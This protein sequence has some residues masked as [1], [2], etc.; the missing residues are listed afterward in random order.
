MTNTPALKSLKAV[1]LASAVSL[2]GACAHDATSDLAK[3]TLDAADSE[4]SV[5]DLGYAAA[6]RGDHSSAIQYFRSAHAQNIAYSSADGGALLGLGQSLLAIGQNSDAANVFIK[7]ANAGSGAPALRGLAQAQLHLG[8]PGLAVESARKAIQLDPNDAKAMG[9]LGISMDVMGDHQG[10]AAIYSDAMSRF[11]GSLALASN[12]GLSMVMTGDLETGV[13]L[14]EDV[15]RDPR[16]RARD[17]Q[18]LSLGYALAGDYDKAAALAAIDLDV[19][20]V[21]ANLLYAD[22]LRAMSPKARLSALVVG[23]QSP[24][25]D[26]TQN[27]N[28][29]YLKGDNAAW[30][31][32]SIRRLVPEEGS[33]D[34]AGVPP[35]MDPTGWAVQ[36]AAYRKLEHLAPGWA[37]LSSKYAGI[38]GG[39]EPRRSEVN[40]PP[41][42]KGPVGFFYRLNAGP[43]RDKQQA[44]DICKQ[45]KARG[46]E[47]WVRPPTAGEG[48]L[49][50]EELASNSS[51]AEG[52]FVRSSDY[53]AVVN[54]FARS[55][56]MKARKDAP[57]STRP[58]PPVMMADVPLE[59]PVPTKKAAKAKAPAA[60]PA[61]KAVKQETIAAAVPAPKPAVAKEEEKPDAPVERPA[62]TTNVAESD[63]L[64]EAA[65]PAEDV[66][67]Q[68]EPAPEAPKTV[69]EVQDTPAPK[70]SEKPAA[71]PAT[72]MKAAA[73]VPAEEADEEGAAATQATQ[74][75]PSAGEPSK[76]D[77]VL[78]VFDALSKADL[79]TQVEEA[80]AKLPMT[81]GSTDD[82]LT[83]APAPGKIIPAMK[84]FNDVPQNL[85]YIHM[86]GG[87]RP[88][89]QETGAPRK[90]AVDVEQGVY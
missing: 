65:K 50:N 45:L 37:Y 64:K 25:T 79:Q 71:K 43:L 83:E 10:A 80:P 81:Q 69:A 46:A 11:P 19:S 39:L 12:H 48:R 76:D 17:R 15:V 60:K 88:G 41:A 36:V 51:A 47:C 9:I 75:E 21:R 28:A 22:M 38:I 63:P 5:V 49:P 87:I 86:S 85:Q 32:A 73:A 18:N 16:A 29:V 58:L 6:A 89:F 3:R 72:V 61:E 23:S 13:R 70:A 82:A 52:A 4:M 59:A 66:K 78:G 26:N 20:G 31:E 90:E 77:P 62:E 42:A 8:Q 54:Q 30:V 35:L 67:T 40:H 33:A 2:L 34:L 44:L 24:K 84:R 57:A 14:L 56:V 55:M 74:L 7:A 53:N 27:A 1:F 68:P